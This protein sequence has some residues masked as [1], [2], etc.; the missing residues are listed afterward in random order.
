M[1]AI[2]LLGFGE[3]DKPVQQYTMETWAALVH[4]FVDEFVQ[5]QPVV[6]MGNSIGSLVALM[7]C[8]LCGGGGCME[9]Y[10]GCM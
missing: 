10:G 7:V 3:S 4:D 2:D 6:L 5:Q 1:Y 8:V 9:V